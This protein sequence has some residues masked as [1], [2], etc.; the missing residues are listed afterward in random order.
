[1]FMTCGNFFLQC[2]GALRSEVHVFPNVS[3]YG[4]SGISGFLVFSEIM[5]QKINPVQKV[6]AVYVVYTSSSESSKMCQV[7]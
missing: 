5:L 2:C 1:M 3:S 7:G 4:L 6:F